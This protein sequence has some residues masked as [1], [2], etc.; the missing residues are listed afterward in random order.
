MRKWLKN[1]R[2]KRGLTQPALAN[3]AG[4]HVTAVNKYELG[5]RTPNPKLAKKIADILGFD[6]ALFYEDGEEPGDAEEE[7][8]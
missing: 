3:L 1:E 7:R 2:N 4:V 5:T 8:Q 6:W